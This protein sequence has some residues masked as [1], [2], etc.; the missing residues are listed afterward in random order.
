VQRGKEAAILLNGKADGK[1]FAMCRIKEGA[2]DKVHS[3][4]C[5]QQSLTT[6]VAFRK[7]QYQLQDREQLICII[8]VLIADACCSSLVKTR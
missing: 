1:L 8:Q 5:V 4:V 3:S 7:R 2:V 6:C